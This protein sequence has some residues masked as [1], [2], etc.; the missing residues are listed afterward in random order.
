[1]KL[2]AIHAAKGLMQKARDYIDHSGPYL[3]NEESNYIVPALPR[4]LFLTTYSPPS[5][6]MY[7]NLLK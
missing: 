4:S 1:M 2:M 6:T 7:Q 3:Q 5:C